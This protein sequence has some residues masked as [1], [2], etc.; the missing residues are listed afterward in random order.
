M[1]SAGAPNFF[2]CFA[3]IYLLF[4]VR[5]CVM[6]VSASLLAI[7]IEISFFIIWLCE[8][9]NNMRVVDV[10]FYN[11]FLFKFGLQIYEI[12]TIWPK[13]VLFTAFLMRSS[14]QKRLQRSDQRN[15]RR[16]NNLNQIYGIGLYRLKHEKIF[17]NIIINNLWCYG[18]F[19]CYTNRIIL[20][21]PVNNSTLS[22]S[23]VF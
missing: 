18:V 3:Q 14:R 16:K 1:L 15:K 21:V 5:H 13:I 10:L 11:F 9:K 17:S 4:S 6:F 12:G 7:I 23:T 8:R 22:K 2:F 20:H 19:D